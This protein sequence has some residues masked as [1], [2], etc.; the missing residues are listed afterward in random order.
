MSAPVCVTG[1]GGRTGSLMNRGG[2]ISEWDQ[3][4]S[5]AHFGFSLTCW[6]RGGGDRNEKPFFLRTFINLMLD[7]EQGCQDDLLQSDEGPCVV[8]LFLLFTASYY[9]ACCS[10][11]KTYV[12]H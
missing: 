6:R 4:F 7:M 5:W 11:M 2:I 12:Q 9:I 8:L 1:H 3:S 10:Y